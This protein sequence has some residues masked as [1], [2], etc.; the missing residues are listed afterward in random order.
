MPSFYQDACRV[1]H[2]SG[3]QNQQYHLLLSPGV[4]SQTGKQQDRISKSFGA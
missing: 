2:D 1:I 4:K 3:K